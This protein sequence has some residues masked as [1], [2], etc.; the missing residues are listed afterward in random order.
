MLKKKFWTELKSYVII[1]LG[2]L[3]YTLGWTIFIIPNNLVGGG[4]TGISAIIH[5]CT[6][7]PVSYSYFI[8]NA[9]LLVIGFKVLGNAFGAKTIFGILIATL[10]L[11]V[12]PRVLDPQFAEMFTQENGLLLSCIIGGGMAG[13]GIAITFSQGGSTGGTDIVAL[14]INKYR[15]ITPGRVIVLLD[16]IIIACTLIIPTEGT[17]V[18]RITRVLYG[19]VIAG[20]CSFTLDA[21][22]SGDKRSVQILVFSHQYQEIAD[23]VAYEVHRGVTVL[24]GQGWFTKNDSKLLLIVVRKQ[25]TN[26]ILQLVKE[27]DNSAFVSVTSVMGVYGKGFEQIKK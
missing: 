15:S 27:I 11:D 13:A 2:L 19:Y 6:G 5:Y 25:E 23:R 3:F 14:I 26:T 1:T 18:V 10:F 20:A 7:F 21:V 24:D 16:A 12:L 4:V 9:V 22:L 8:I 17:W